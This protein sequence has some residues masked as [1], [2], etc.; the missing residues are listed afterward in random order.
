MGFKKEM[1]QRFPSYLFRLCIIFFY[2]F[3][4]FE[5]KNC[6]TNKSKLKSKK[7]KKMK[8]YITKAI[9]FVGEIV[10]IKLFN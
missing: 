1:G 3:E 10:V 6:V 4:C 5:K 2:K 8:I 7:L 9:M